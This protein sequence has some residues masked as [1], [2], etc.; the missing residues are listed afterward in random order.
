[1]TNAVTIDLT[2]TWGEW[3]NIYARL[4]ES[5]ERKAVK[6]LRADLA[7]MAASSEALKALAGTLT[8][9]QSAIVSRI[10]VAEIG[11]QVS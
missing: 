2:P 4:A 9:E 5:G 8:D 10:L 11:K 7:R 6:S 1:M 3:A